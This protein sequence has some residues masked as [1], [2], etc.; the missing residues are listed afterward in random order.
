MMVESVAFQGGTQVAKAG[1]SGI[2]H[3]PTGRFRRNEHGCVSGNRLRPSQQSRAHESA[4]EPGHAQRYVRIG[5]AA[6]D[7]VRGET[8]G[9]SPEVRVNL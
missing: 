1:S 9:C 7:S 2:G 8:R 6:D 3:W 4:P 5:R